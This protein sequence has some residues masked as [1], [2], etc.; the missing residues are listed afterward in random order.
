M[1][2]PEDG[3]AAVYARAARP[4]VRA[5]LRGVNGT[6][7]AYGQTSSGKTHTMSGVPSDPG[8]MQRA[9]EDIFERVE[10]DRDVRR[11]DVRC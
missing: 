8:V 3:N 11:Y 7:M 5:V 9:V 4:V 2:A 10:R 1:F 6:V